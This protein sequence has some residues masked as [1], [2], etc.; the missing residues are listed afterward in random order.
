MCHPKVKQPYKGFGFSQKCKWQGCD[1]NARVRGYCLKHYQ[2][3]F[4]RGVLNE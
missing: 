4:V 2:A 3:V 1:A